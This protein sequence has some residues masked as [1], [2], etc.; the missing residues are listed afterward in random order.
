MARPIPREAPVIKQVD[1]RRACLE[2]AKSFKDRICVEQTDEAGLYNVRATNP[3]D[4][5]AK[6]R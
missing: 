2:E 6:I 4:N 5:E 1:L 3:D